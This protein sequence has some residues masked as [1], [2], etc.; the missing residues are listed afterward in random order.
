M[1]S[2]QKIRKTLTE[3]EP[4]K[5]KSKVRYNKTNKKKKNEQNIAEEITI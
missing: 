3:I 4:K 5:D 2:T 1:Y